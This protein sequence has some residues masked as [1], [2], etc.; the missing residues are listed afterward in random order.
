MDILI[1]Q[2]EDGTGKFVGASDKLAKNF[3]GMVS[4]FQDVWFQFKQQIGEPMFEDLKLDMQAVLTLIKQTKNQGGQY[5][6]VV[7]NLSEAMR[8]AYDISKDLFGFSIVAA[9]QLVDMVNEVSF[10]MN[11]NVIIWGTVYK[12]ILEANLAKNKFFKQWSAVDE[13]IAELKALSGWMEELKNKNNDLAG[14]SAEDWSQAVAQQVDDFRA[15]IEEQKRIIADAQEDRKESEVQASQEISDQK[16]EI[17]EAEKESYLQKEDEK[18]EE[19]REKWQIWQQEK[20]AIELSGYEAQKEQFEFFIDTQQKAYQSLWTVAG[21][22]RDT[23]TS[24]MS[25]ALGNLIT[26]SGS[27]KKA[28]ASMGQQM[29]Q[30]LI[31]WGVQRAVN[32]ALSKAFMAAE[33]QAAKAAGAAT[34]NAWADA[35]A[36]V[37][38]ATMGANAL[39]ASAGI[40]S[41]VGIAH[42]IALPELADGGIVKAAN[43]GRIVRVAE[44]GQDEAVIPLERG[45]NR[46]D[47]LMGPGAG[48]STVVIEKIV[49][50]G[51]AD[52]KNVKDLADEIGEVFKR[53]QNYIRS[54]A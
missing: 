29:V 7:Q 48:G 20:N 49:I 17:A 9:A 18:L 53:E 34:A 19:L 31:D 26:Q 50:N 14:K 2:W 27:A 33:V 38:L 54:V 39:P 37:S 24:G 11:R 1:S 30:I 35:A 21:Q 45:R 32:F 4:M 28:F 42:A 43:G 25:K 6:D 44:G 40:V 8:D 51:N 13:N 23:F 41:T 36:M 46:L 16:M 52:E 15:S 10:H 3:T 5:D 47:R 12:K 22:A